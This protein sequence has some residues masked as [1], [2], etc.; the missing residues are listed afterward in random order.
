ME[1]IYEDIKHF[2][3]LKDWKIL[4]HGQEC[5]YFLS[6]T[7]GSTKKPIVPCDSLPKLPLRQVQIEI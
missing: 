7:L 2:A 3:H 4:K 1:L 6:P 5:P